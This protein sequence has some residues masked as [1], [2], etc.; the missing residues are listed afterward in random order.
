MK[1]FKKQRFDDIII[2]LCLVFVVVSA[3]FAQDDLYNKPVEE[4]KKLSLSECI[5]LAMENSPEIIKAQQEIEISR[6][7]LAEARSGYFPKLNA[8]VSYNYFNTNNIIKTPFPDDLISTL[9]ETA[10]MD[11]LRNQAMVSGVNP[12]SGSAIT[13][14]DVL[15]RLAA[16]NRT[17]PTNMFN[18]LTSVARQQIYDN[19]DNILWTPLMGNNYF[20]TELRVRQ[21]IFLWG[22][23]YNKNKQAKA[24][25]GASRS[26]LTKIKNDVTYSVT[27]RYNQVLLAKDG[28]ELAKETELK[29]STL[30]DLIKA[31]YEGEAENVTKL[32]YLEVEATLGLV[33]SKVYELE[34]TL[35]LSKAALKQ[36]IGI[37]DE[38]YVDALED[39]Q[40]Y[41]LVD[42]S[43]NDSI[44]KAML[45]RPE[46]SKLEFGIEAKK[47]EI[48]AV[49]AENRPKVI[50][51]SAFD[52]NVDNKDYLEPDPVDFRLSVIADV[53]LFDGLLTRAKVNQHKHELE[54]LKQSRRQ[55]KNGVMLEVIDAVL[56]VEEMKKTLLASEEAVNSAVENQSLARESF[57]L[58]I[59]ES[60]KVIDAQV[61]EAKVKT[62][63][64]LSIFNYNVAKA[65]LKKVMGVI[66]SLSTIEEFEINDIAP[67]KQENNLFLMEKPES[68][69]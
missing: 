42:I 65:K 36:T 4:V 52:V 64:L 33:K 29:F 20:K 61:L 17:T 50:L 62:Q 54:Q 27:E 38:V 67:N 2:S 7:K 68:I 11:V 26:E 35:E 60:K 18:S 44:H 3:S 58:E 10:V 24:G 66:D 34:K 59:I 37:D 32:D 21:P 9:S 15:A 30:R 31:L 8:Q 1:V 63:L 19:G 43:M 39:K 22:L 45:N 57:E 46:F 13:E 69:L 47:R 48:K 49:R 23:V 5:N 6:A 28:L 14:M 25:I 16:M 12:I 55:L 53:P 56:S 40:T 51:D 41:D